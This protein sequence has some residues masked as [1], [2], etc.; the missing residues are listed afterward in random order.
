MVVEREP[1]NISQIASKSARSSARSQTPQSSFS[2]ILTKVG[3]S[4]VTDTSQEVKQLAPPFSF[5]KHSVVPS[6][7]PDPDLSDYL[8][9]SKPR[10]RKSTK[11]TI[12]TLPL[13][14]VREDLKPLPSNLSSISYSIDSA[15]KRQAI[16]VEDSICKQ[17]D[18]SL[19]LSPVLQQKTYSRLDESSIVDPTSNIIIED[20]GNSLEALVRKELGRLQT[21]I[22]EEKE[23]HTAMLVQQAK[24]YEAKVAALQRA[25]SQQQAKWEAEVRT[26]REDVARVKRDGT[27][28]A[29]QS[30]LKENLASDYRHALQS[31]ETQHEEHTRQRLQSI[32]H[33]YELR[34]RSQQEQL[35]HIQQHNSYLKEQ[36]TPQSHEQKAVR[37]LLEE[38]EALRGELA[39][40]KQRMVCGR[41]KCECEY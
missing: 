14:H 35:A 30:D 39:D 28:R 25:V 11:P 22:A 16:Y 12:P 5:R 31:K 20:T 41:C 33:D 13:D 34:L 21:A 8:T 24:Q 29:P 10:P 3:G 18:N 1:V 19:L 7:P 32:K 15:G 6:C 9:T 17:E 40:I 26:L 27:C 2:R 23:A 36:L 38:N 37:A 4:Q